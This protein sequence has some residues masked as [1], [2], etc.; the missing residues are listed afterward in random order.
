MIC[1][2]C[3]AHERFR[4]LIQLSQDAMTNM[5]DL[6]LWPEAAV[7][8]LLR[9]NKDSFTAVTN[10]AGSN[11]V[12]LIIGADDMEIRA[13][14]SGKEAREFFN[15]SFLVSPEGRLVNSYKKRALVIFGEY[16]PLVTWLRSEEHT[17]ELQ[18]LR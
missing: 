14:A 4:Q 18:S 8:K 10:L 17:S 5:P 2:P 12:W 9:W 6:L 11:H 16:I 3:N 15:S 1:V 7:P 13:D